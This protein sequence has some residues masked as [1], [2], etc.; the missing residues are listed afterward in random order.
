M[1]L[2]DFANGS[3]NNSNL[4]RY[5]HHDLDEKMESIV[6][7]LQHR[8]PEEVKVDFIEASP[9]LKKCLGKAY[10]RNKFAD[11]M[12]TFIRIRK[13]VAE[14]GGD[15]LVEVIAHEMAH[16]YLYQKGFTDATEKSVLF[17]WVCGRVKADPTGIFRGSEEWDK[18][19]GPFMEK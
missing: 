12:S 18:V 19:I 7:D 9:M 14:E 16:I 8:F 15:E 17:Q 11:N 3:S 2:D 10:Y 1:G 5:N 13:D 4:K 6:D